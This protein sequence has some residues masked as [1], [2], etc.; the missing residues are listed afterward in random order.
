MSIPFQLGGLAA[1][2]TIWTNTAGSTLPDGHTSIGAA[3]APSYDHFGVFSLLFDC[4]AN[5]PD[6]STKSNPVIRAYAIPLDNDD[7]NYPDI[8]T[9]AA[10]VYGVNVPMMYYIGSW[11][12][13]SIKT[14]PQRQQFVADIHKFNNRYWRMAITNNTGAAFLN[15]STTRVTVRTFNEVLS[16]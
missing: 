3:I 7:T 15:T 14:A 5:V 16:N 9:G 10:V 11:N 12:L 4:A 1:S 13:L 8:I 6:L 2:Q